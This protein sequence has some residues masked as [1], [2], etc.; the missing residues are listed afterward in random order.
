MQ[1]KTILPLLAVA[2]A[3]C[4][5]AAVSAGAATQAP[6]R[7]V[8][9][10]E[11]P[12]YTG[13]FDHFGVDVPG[14]RL[15]LAGEDGGSLEVFD[16]HTARHLRSVKGFEAPHAIV[17]LPQAHRLVVTDS[18]AGMSKV[19]DAT[20]YKVT[21]TIPLTPGADSTRYDPSTGHLWI[22]TGGKNADPKM[23]NVVVSEVD[24]ATGQ[25]LGDV[26]FDTDFTE[27]M[28]AEQHGNRL[29][30]NVA[31]K[32]QVAVVDKTART[33]SATWPIKEGEQNGAMAFDELGHRLFVV[34]RKPFRLVVLNSDTGATVAS[35][36]A[37]VRTNEAVWDA[38][39]HRLYLAGDDHIAV[40]TQQGPDH[41]EMLPPVPSAH[42]AKTAIL[43]PEIHRLFVAVSP[44][45]AKGGAV[46]QYDVT[47]S[48]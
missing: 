6:L 21:G 48:P 38:G 41:Y 20:T 39:N 44:G 22:V 3:T 9:R 45:D 42:G 10:T 19:L 11:L 1:T 25:R 7:L 29:F 28:A 4:G 27:A 17:Y 23:P 18:G 40:I 24:A 37:P 14:H 13:D 32:S 15:F 26:G 8:T 12:D 16:L 47:P 46:L 34:T 36:D 43:V 31:G 5:T 2:L 33:V 30:I 35:F